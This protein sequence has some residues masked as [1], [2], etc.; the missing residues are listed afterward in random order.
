MSSETQPA[1]TYP[2]ATQYEQWKNRADSMDMSI[3]E[4]IQ[5]MVEAG[6]KKFDA[7]VTPDETASELREQRNNVMDDLDT[8]RKRV[9][10]LR[11]RLADSE[12]ETVRF[13][14]EQ[15]PGAN[16][17]NIVDAVR[18]TAPERVTQH[19]DALTGDEL[20]TNPNGLYYP[21][22]ASGEGSQ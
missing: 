10:D 1:M 12:R 17:Q 5:A 13:H 4:Y 15:N 20:R 16:Y 9:S 18:A 8:C 2:T 7:S 21:A 6:N 19:L 22:E 11:K 3:S 14:V